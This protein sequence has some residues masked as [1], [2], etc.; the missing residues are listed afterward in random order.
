MRCLFI[1]IYLLITYAYANFTN[2]VIVDYF[3]YK[4]VSSVIGYSCNGIIDDA[5]LVKD[6]NIKGITSAL[7]KITNGSTIHFFGFADFYKLGIIL[8]TRCYNWDE[9][10]SILLEATDYR[11]YD[12]L[13][14]WLII[15]YDL[16]Y[17]AD[18]I[19]DEAFGISTNFVIAISSENGEYYQLYDVYNAAKDKGGTLNITL[20]GDWKIDTKL[21]IILTQ[22]KL[23][24]RL[25][26]HGIVLQASF[27]KTVYRPEGMNV[28]DYFQSYSTAKKES[29]A[30]FGYNMLVDLSQ[31]LNF[32]LECISIPKWESSDRMGPLVRSLVNNDADINGIVMIMSVART[33]WIKFVSEI[34]PTRT[35]FLFRNPQVE[36][37][38]FKEIFR[39]FNSNVW[40]LI[41]MVVGSGTAILTLAS[42]FD[43][44]ESRSMRISQS[45]ILMVG[46][47]CQQGTN[48]Q[49]TYISIRIAF[50]SITMFGLLIYNYYS[51]SVVSARFSEPII[52]INDSL[53]EL[54]KLP[55]QFS[56]E[57]IPWF[58]FYITR[59][60]WETKLF[61]K[62]RWSVLPEDKRYVPPEEGLKL[63]KH[64][65]FAYHTSPD[66][67]Y[68]FVDKYFDNHELC[69]LM[70]VHLIRPTYA[71]FGVKMNSTIVEL[72]RYGFVRLSEVGI[73]FRH[74][75]KWKYRTLKCRKDILTVSSVDIYEF[76]PHLILL[77][78]GL[79]I[80]IF[81]VIAEVLSIDKKVF[82]QRKIITKTF[83]NRGYL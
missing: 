48:A 63:M 78:I 10:H 57:F 55:L 1:C 21:N 23:F 20:T 49:M 52:K 81:L 39:P 73:R 61:Y 83:F 36:K 18:N 58:L 14:Y 35:C 2:N 38:K 24:R 72:M 28:E 59:D 7:S 51:T 71:S 77:L 32:R 37:I 4:K 26:L 54:S 46:A 67:A 12:E 16:T 50:L 6:F 17:I 33:R 69:E 43:W 22:S 70:E 65:G 15:G 19:N 31:L 40:Y 62:K 66:V 42:Q 8:D 76:A 75:K 64:G 47:I 9:I 5:Q 80:S 30:K 25:N 13:R 56:A 44:I 11:M 82:C 45:S 3:Y 74:I 68:P 60:D 53:N 41:M 27:F 34:F 79:L 29:T